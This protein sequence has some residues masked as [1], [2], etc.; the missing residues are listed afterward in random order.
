MTK[1]T[2]SN[3][4]CGAKSIRSAK[5]PDNNAIINALA[6]IAQA[7]T[8]I[9]EA[10]QTTLDRYQSTLLI[11]HSCWHEQTIKDSLLIVPQW[12]HEPYGCTGGDYWLDEENNDKYQCNHCNTIHNLP[13]PL[14]TG[15]FRYMFG[16]TVHAAYEKGQLAFSGFEQ[17]DLTHNT[18][19]TTSTFLQNNKLT[20][21]SPIVD[22]LEL[23]DKPLF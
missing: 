9:S 13:Y 15:S 22:I 8:V 3:F 23:L 1:A 18:P 11:C 2:T 20:E 14:N 10:I 5:R 19:V 16:K 17:K 4:T 7:R 12:Y 21:D 6:T